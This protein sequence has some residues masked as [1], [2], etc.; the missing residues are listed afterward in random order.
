[1]FIRRPLR[2]L[3]AAGLTAIA[4]ASSAAAETGRTGTFSGEND[5]VVT[6]SVTVETGAD[7]AAIVLGENFTLDGA[8]DPKVAYAGEGG[9]PIVLSVPL[10]A[11]AGAQSYARNVQS[12]LCAEGERIAGFFYLGSAAQELA[13]RPRPSPKAIIS[14]W[15]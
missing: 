15:P 14:K 10:R 5:H 11:L 9:E 4:L 12:A 3:A 7:G 13:E 8:P 2:T 6:G 1:M